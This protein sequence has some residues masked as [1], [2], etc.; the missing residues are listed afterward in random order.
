M[1]GFTADVDFYPCKVQKIIRSFG[2]NIIHSLFHTVW[3]S[4]FKWQAFTWREETGTK[5]IERRRQ[6]S[7]V[8]EI[9]N[10]EAKETQSFLSY[11]TIDNSSSITKLNA[12]D[13]IKSKIDSF[14]KSFKWRSKAPR[15]KC[16]C[17]F[18][19]A[20]L[21]SQDLISYTNLILHQ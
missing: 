16:K 18:R 15:L 19:P 11:E 8:K 3:M 4:S 2:V 5:W 20:T 12:T 13:S 7:R 21:T 10:A 6:T 14:D 1:L 17:F 9:T